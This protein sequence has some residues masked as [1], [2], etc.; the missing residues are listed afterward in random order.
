VI[1][2]T[3]DGV[4]IDV[5]VIP[6]AGTSGPAGTRDGRLLIRLSA[7]PVEGAANAAL[8]ELLSQL[9][10]RPKRMIRIVSG[11]HSRSKCV[12]VTGLTLAE[13]NMRLTQQ[14]ASRS[15]N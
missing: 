7:A 13:A 5:R 11:E 15:P 14:N 2:S 12:V 4:E 3:S 10:D 1:R 8:I 6:R 9:L